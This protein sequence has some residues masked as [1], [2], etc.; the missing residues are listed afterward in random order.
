[1]LDLNV[2]SP[3]EIH[4]E[5]RKYCII[6]L[7]HCRQVLFNS[8]SSHSS[9]IIVLCCEQSGDKTLSVGRDWVQAVHDSFSFVTSARLKEFLESPD[10]DWSRQTPTAASYTHIKE[11]QTSAIWLVEWMHSNGR[12]EDV[13]GDGWLLRDLI[14]DNFLRDKRPWCYDTVITQ[15]QLCYNCL[16]H[17]CYN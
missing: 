2:F 11:T 8:S 1:M 9:A 6:S 16:W 5:K 17:N 15:L 7:L 3:L 14:T 12:L 10:Y 13:Y 4:S